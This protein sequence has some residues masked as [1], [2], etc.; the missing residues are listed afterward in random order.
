LKWSIFDTKNLN[1]TEV[2]FPFYWIRSP[3]FVSLSGLKKYLGLLAT[4][5]YKSHH[6]F[7]LAT[8]IITA[9]R[10][11]ALKLNQFFFN[12]DTGCNVH[13]FCCCCMGVVVSAQAQDFFFLCRVRS[14]FNVGDLNDRS[15]L[16]KGMSYASSEAN[17]LA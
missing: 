7:H 10:V 5:A 8:P 16:T 13:C 4:N 3:V 14:T 15:L 17:K 12:W 2:S 1:I 11:C 6:H 9:E